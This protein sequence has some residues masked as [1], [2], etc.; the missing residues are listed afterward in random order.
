[1]G[2]GPL[3]VA[4][5]GTQVL[6]L[7]LPQFAAML[8]GAN[9]T[10]DILE[11]LSFDLLI[12]DLAAIDDTYANNSSAQI[13]INAPS[14]TRLQEQSNDSTLIETG[15]PFVINYSIS[16]GI[17]NPS[18]TVSVTAGECFNTVME[19]DYNLPGIA[20]CP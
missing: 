1:M 7:T 6:Q 10:I 16:D 9:G 20:P 11:T 19:G 3:T 15:G 8:N 4:I 14:N 17:D 18:G 5:D 2:D 12:S 13:S